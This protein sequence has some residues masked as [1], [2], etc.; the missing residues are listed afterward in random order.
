MVLAEVLQ[1]EAFNL[2]KAK[3]TNAKGS[4]FTTQKTNDSITTTLVRK[5]ERDLPEIA[6]RF[7][8]GEILV[9]ERLHWN[10]NLTTAVINVDIKNAPISIFGQLILVPTS[11]WTEVI[12]DLEFSSSLPFFGEKIENFAEKIWNDV[13]DI[14]FQLIKN[15]FKQQA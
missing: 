13:S 7:M 8:G 6:Q 4:N 5:F 15:A 1:S 14:E 3:A 9:T 11:L 2:K 12:L 10:Q